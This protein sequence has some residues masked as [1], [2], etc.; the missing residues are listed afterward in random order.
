MPSG[1]CFFPLC[2]DVSWNLL[3]CSQKHRHAICVL[4]RLYMTTTLNKPHYLPSVCIQA[5]I[6][7]FSVTFEGLQEQL[8]SSVVHQEKPLLEME[9]N[10]LRESLAIDLQLLHDLEDKMLG[11][12]QKAQ[13]KEVKISCLASWFYQLHVCLGSAGSS[14]GY[15]VL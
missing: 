5:N 10:Q 6:V 12:L 11:I 4:C 1:C 8:L 9:R 13:G 2:C 3:S 14:S 15:D 7:N